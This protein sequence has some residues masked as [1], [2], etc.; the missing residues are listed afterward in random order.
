MM[1]I[2]FPFRVHYRVYNPVY[3]RENGVDVKN[4]K[5]VGH[6]FAGVKTYGGSET[7]KNGV[8]VVRD[9]AVLHTWYNTICKTDSR[10]IDDTGGIWSIITPPED[11]D[12]S[13][14]FLSFRIERIQGGA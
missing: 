4:W 8:T 14:R 13:K 12:A 9:T 6:I 2:N 3:T 7:E 1:K 5:D 11:I 10:L